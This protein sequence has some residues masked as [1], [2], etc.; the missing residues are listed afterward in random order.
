MLAVV[1]Q[2]KAFGNLPAD[3]QEDI[4]FYNAAQLYSIDPPQA[5]RAIAAE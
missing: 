2:E 4:T 1:L 5:G 3:V